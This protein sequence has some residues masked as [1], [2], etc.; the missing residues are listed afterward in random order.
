MCAVFS[1]PGKQPTHMN[2]NTKQLYPRLLEYARPYWKTFSFAIA[3]T[4]VFAL[5]EPAMPAIFGK[6]LD[7]SFISSDSDQALYYSLMLIGVFVVRGLAQYCSTVAMGWVGHK[8]IMDLRKEM[9]H[10]LML[11]PTQI[12]DTQG[13]GSLLSKFTY[14]VSQVYEATTT[15]MV[16]LVRDSVTVLALLAY[17]LYVDWQLALLFFTI[18]PII[19]LLI[20]SIS[21][22]LRR[23]NQSHMSSVGEMNTIA[24][25]VINGQKEVRLFGGQAYENQRFYNA[26][27]W[28]RRYVMK[29]IITSSASVPIVQV[30]AAIALAVIINIA[31]K[32]PEM[33]VGTFVAFFTAM[34]LLLSPIK[35][36]TKVNESI[37]RGLAAAQSVFEVLDTPGE[38][39]TGTTHIDRARGKLEFRH[40]SFR[41]ANSER[42]ALTDI[43]LVIQQGETIALVGQ[44]GSGKSTLAGL[45]PRFYLPTSGQI[46]L[47]DIDIQELTLTSLRNNLSLV[48]QQVIL[49]NDTIAANI[50]Y[51]GKQDASEAEIIQAAQKA[52]A[53][54]FIRELPDGLQ[55]LCGKNGARLS[56]GQRQRIAIAR[57]L[58]K[59]APILIL[60]EA[61]SALDTES[62]QKV[63]DALDILMEGRTTIT[64]AH[65]LSTIK[66]ADRIVV[67]DRGRIAEVGSHDELLAK[68]GRYADLYRIQ[69]SGQED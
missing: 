42:D 9:F 31:A 29:T 45:I 57:A 19:G 61:T 39:D 41:Y 43:S 37:Q 16:V 3:A 2:S 64:I 4:I 7:G 26:I 65:R 56:G 40:L 32:D 17:L 15:A 13:S 11:A 30:L 10:K 62:E 18:I 49:F 60:D 67:L 68:G 14:D 44:S 47:D 5:T 8:I 34:S 24:E 38:P 66:K 58:L 33:T 28:A 12:F 53:M 55:T 59:D 48:S 63:Q 46:L 54:E 23:L 50:A 35:R 52:H 25:E 21:L 6:L 36:L 27:N 22:R 69:F 51:G 20:K 1:A